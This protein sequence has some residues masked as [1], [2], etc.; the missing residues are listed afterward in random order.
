MYHGKD[1]FSSYGV[2]GIL[3]LRS[4]IG[5]K[6]TER[7]CVAFN[8]SNKHEIQINFI[9]LVHGGCIACFGTDTSIS[10]YK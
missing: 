3:S 1:D 2:K 9:E 10:G 8:V 4:L 6:I 7:N 5:L